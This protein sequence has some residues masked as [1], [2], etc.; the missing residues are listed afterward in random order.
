MDDL[1]GTQEPIIRL[2][3]PAEA[4]AALERA[5]PGL[6]A[7]RLPASSDIAWSEVEA[8]LGAV[9]PGDYKRLCELYPALEFND[10]LGFAGPEPGHEHRWIRGR[11]EELELIAEW[12]E[13]ADLAVPLHPYPAPGGLLPWASS[14]EGDHFLWTTLGGPDRW[15]VTVASR[16]GGWWHYTG[17][18]VQFLADL[19]SGV[20]EPWGLPPLRPEARKW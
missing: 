6:A 8:E 7:L 20:L 3:D 1:V 10:F 5:V 14:N 16:N 12:C 9:L 11:R 4:V 13:E 19:V 17:G 15:T 2:A 18:A